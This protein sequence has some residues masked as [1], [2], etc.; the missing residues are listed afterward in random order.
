[1][2]LT[3]EDIQRS[4]GMSL[5]QLLLAH[6]PG[7]ELVR[8]S[9]G[10]TILHLRRGTTSMMGEQEP[11]VVV[12]GIALGPNASGNLSAINREDIES[13]TVLRDAAATAAWGSRGTN[14][15]III[16]TKRG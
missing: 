13:I 10:R 16:R 9:D 1:M 5:E 14:G 11:L 3:A 8:A 6:V 12:N 15:V 2:V 7:L 4:P